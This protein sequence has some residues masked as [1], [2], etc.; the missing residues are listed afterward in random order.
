VEKGEFDLF[1]PLL[2]RN[3]LG[4]NVSPFSQ[5]LQLLAKFDIFNL[6]NSLL[7]FD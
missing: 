2:H 4:N 7:I 5:V 6:A 3:D 1:E